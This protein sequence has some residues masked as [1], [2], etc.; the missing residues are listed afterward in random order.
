MDLVLY[1]THC[2]QCNVLIN[3]LKEKKL[4]FELNENIEEMKSLGFKSS[5][6]LKVDDKFLNFK[7]A[8]KWINEVNY[9]R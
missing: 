8:F 9:E 2:P 4:E 6:M 7:E 5:P 3:K 1:S